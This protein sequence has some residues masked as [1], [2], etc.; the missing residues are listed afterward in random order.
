VREGHPVLE[1]AALLWEKLRAPLRNLPAFA[2]AN[3]VL[4]SPSPSSWQMH[5][6]K[7]SAE[8]GRRR[9]FAGGGLET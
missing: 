9:S 6:L 5:L 1:S 4:M 2:M 3:Q 8:I 7:W